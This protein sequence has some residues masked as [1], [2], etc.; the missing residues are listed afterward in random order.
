MLI[1]MELKKAARNKGV[2]LLSMVIVLL[3]FLFYFNYTSENSSVFEYEL[4]DIT[5]GISFGILFYGMLFLT[6][7]S[8]V[9]GVYL[10]NYDTNQKTIYNLIVLRGRYLPYI[11]KIISM[12]VLHFLFLITLSILMAIMGILKCGWGNINIKTIMVQLIFMVF[13]GFCTSLLAFVISILIQNSVISNIIVILFLYIPAMLGGKISV[14]LKYLNP[15]K[16]FEGKLDTIFQNIT[17][18]ESIHIKSGAFQK[19]YLIGGYILICMCILFVVLRKRNY[20]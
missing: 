15:M 10:G 19:W 16:Y 13:I 20:R 8:S 7:W 11:M 6:I 14:F 1:L 4:C 3:L 9:I 2:K 18:L 12:F 5:N 17:G